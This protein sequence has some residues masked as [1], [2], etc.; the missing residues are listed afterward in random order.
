MSEIQDATTIDTQQVSAPTDN[1]GQAKFDTNGVVIIGG[2]VRLY[3]FDM[4]GVSTIGYDAYLT[5]GCTVPEGAT[6][7]SP[8]STIGGTSPIFDQKTKTWS[9]IT[10]H[11]GETVYVKKTQAK[12][13]IDYVGEYR[14]DVTPYP[15]S[16]VY[17]TWNEQTGVWDK[18]P[19]IVGENKAVTNMKL[20]NSELSRAEQQISIMND[21][22]E[23]QYYD[24]NET[25]AMVRESLLHWK[26][27]RIQCTQYISGVL[28]TVPNAPDSQEYA[29][30]QQAI[31]DA[32]AAQKTADEAAE[33][34][35]VADEEAASK[36]AEEA[37]QKSADE[38]AAQKAAEEAA[39]KAA[40]DAAAKKAAEEADA[41]DDAAAKDTSDPAT[42]TS[43]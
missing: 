40:D 27:Y 39:Q 24:P 32:E 34:Q 28:K 21:K 10:D 6:T 35:K 26:R 20:V 29:A 33:A 22:L 1:Q 23:I 41:A 16:S 37:A 2:N 7:I 42:K 11:R 8:P 18:D 19:A 15:P 38:A 31:A 9:E 30:E 17:D 12:Y 43:E 14:S 36:V 5:V 3:G 4:L 25:E 13:V